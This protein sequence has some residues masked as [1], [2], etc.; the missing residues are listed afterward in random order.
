ME[1]RGA[2][3]QAL[4]LRVMRLT[5]PLPSLRSGLPVSAALPVESIADFPDALLRAAP[6]WEGEGA[7]CGVGAMTILP[8]SF[9]SIFT[10]ETFR[11]IIA[12][13]NS[14]LDAAAQVSVMV[15]LE[16]ASTQ[17]RRVLV[18]TRTSPLPHLAA[19]SSTTHV[20][21]AHLPDSGVH[22]LKCAATY[23]D[24]TRQLK[25]FRQFY[26]FNVLAPLE[27]AVAVLPLPAPMPR[28]GRTAQSPL[29]FLVELRLLNVTPAPVYINDV[30]LQSRPAYVAERL[31]DDDGEADAQPGEKDGATGH[32]HPMETLV[33]ENTVPLPTRRA[34]LGVGD[35]RSFLFL[36]TRRADDGDSFDTVRV[37]AA[38][39]QAER[40]SL[41]TAIASA[42]EAGDP[43]GAQDA[44]RARALALRSAERGSP[45]SQ[46]SSRGGSTRRRREMGALQV[47]WRTALGEVGRMECAAVAHEPRRRRAEVELSVVAVPAKIRA[48][49]PFAATCSVRNNT[50]RPLK[51][52][53]QVRRDLVGEIVPVGVSG[54]Q[55]SELPPGEKVECSLTLL[56][57]R[58]GQHAISGVR[59]F[60]LVTKK[61]YVAEP[62]VVSVL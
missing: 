35:T 19:R 40:A 61:A 12:V 3:K 5:T 6:G 27:P 17:R 21:S 49:C 62:P 45:S 11:S 46:G 41:R 54:M 55:L 57:L 18:D 2:G 13:Y 28:P 34:S 47:S 31:A 60:D 56:P 39:L 43:G 30:V 26:R 22:V 14:G 24:P 53:L 16:T 48:Q 42:R 15:E 37:A 1:H 23:I 38:Q 36:V 33:F 25:V 4:I 10:S 7:A 58:S 9:G 20:V 32:S 8:S 51:L 50:V 44:L 52:Y 59:V 29:H